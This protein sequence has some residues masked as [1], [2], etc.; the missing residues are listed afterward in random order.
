MARCRH[1]PS[2]VLATPIAT[3]TASIHLQKLAPTYLR[4][5]P[6]VIL[7]KVIKHDGLFRK[8]CYPRGGCPHFAEWKDEFVNK[9]AARYPF[10]IRDRGQRVSVRLT[11]QHVRV[12]MYP[13]NQDVQLH[14]HYGSVCSAFGVM[15]LV[16]G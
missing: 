2:L 8:N 6:R 14:T 1:P 3:G 7:L 10:A 9:L 11:G 15:F 4:G 12:K 5:L 13:E 16:F